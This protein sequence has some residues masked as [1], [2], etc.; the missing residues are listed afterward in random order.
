MTSWPKIN[1]Q[2]NLERKNAMKKVVNLISY[3]ILGMLLA[4]FSAPSPAYAIGHYGIPGTYLGGCDV[5]H[6][7]VHGVYEPT[8]ELP[9]TG[10]LRWVK[11]TIEWP[12]GTVYS[13]VTYTQQEDLTAPFD[14][15]MAD[16]NDADLDGPCEVCHTTTHYH[17][18]TPDGTTHY[19]GE[20]CITCHPHFTDDLENYFQ[21]QFTGSQAHDTHWTDLKG[22]LLGA[23]NCTACHYPTDYSLFADGQPL[24]TTTVCDPCHSPGGVGGFDGVG[25]Y[26]P[27]DTPEDDTW[28]LAHPDSV[29]YGAKYNWKEGIYD[30]D[31]ITLKDGKNDWCASCH[32]N[33][34]STVNAIYAP[35]VMGDN[36]IWGYNVTGHGKDA[37]RC[38]DCHIPDLAVAHCDGEAR[39]Y[40]APLANYRSGYR[41]NED[42]AVPRYGEINPEAFRL[43]TTSCHD[44]VD[45]TGDES[46]FRDDGSQTQ[47]HEIHLE[48]WPAWIASDSD[49][50][51]VDCFT[52]ACQDSAMTCVN[53]HNV[54]GPPNPA[55]IRHG[56]LMG[57]A[58][59]SD[60]V[61]AL[62]FYWL[63]ADGT[64]HTT[65][66][67]ESRYGSLICG[68]LPDAS[69]NYVCSGCH[70]SE[71]L[72]WFRNPAGQQGITL[73]AVWTT[74]TS[75]NTK[76]QFDIN[77]PEAFRVHASFTLVGTGTGPYFVQIANSA[78]G[79][80]S[81]MDGPDWSFPLTKQGTVGSGSFEV[82]WQGTIPATAGNGSPAKV[83]MRIYVYNYQGGTLLDQDEMTWDF[84]TADVP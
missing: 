21:P 5:C 67:A 58:G 41:L 12:S 32:D 51:G 17:S 18:N 23:S 73:D 27:L 33:G 72:T 8:P 43:C 14:G 75:D 79:N 3:G 59:T 37:V 2:P 46:K 61:P 29:A 39:T 55:M 6:D 71:R 81:T 52:G 31:G 80:S 84:S 34:T 26:D 38:T 45:V 60:R 64:T 53:C 16:G 47:Y 24:A 82:Q 20:Y 76:T 50:D 40:S 48:W 15:T 10:N 65:V 78:V 54:H 19:D 44:Y 56:E 70:T 83:I 69:V 42:M 1:R 25:E 22:P 57:T 4:A 30:E 36:S 74:D 62:D 7:F 68:L 13:G 28:E 66:L 11:S 9:G 77:P 35:N 63:K 49:F